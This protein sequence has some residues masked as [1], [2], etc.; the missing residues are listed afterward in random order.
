MRHLVLLLIPLLIIEYITNYVM[1]TQAD[2]DLQWKVF[3]VSQS[4]IITLCAAIIFYLY[5]DSGNILHKYSSIYFLIIS[6]TSLIA[7]VCE[8]NKHGDY[9][10]AFWVG[11]III[12][13]SHLLYLCTK[14]ILIKWPKLKGF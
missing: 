11:L 9:F 12:A 8:S 10:E 1:L 14:R 2:A 3:F 13:I 4:L 6:L 5:R 7:E